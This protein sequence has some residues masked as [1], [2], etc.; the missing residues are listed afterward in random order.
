MADAN[1]YF[2]CL[3]AQLA[4]GSI[5]EPGN[6]GRIIHAYTL[7]QNNP[8]GISPV[9]YR[10][11]ILELVRKLVAPKKPSRLNCVFACPT[12]EDLRVFMSARNNPFDVAYEVETFDNPAIH[13]AGHDIPLLRFQQNDPYFSKMEDLAEEYWI[14]APPTNRLE[15]VIGGPVKVIRRL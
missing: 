13:I 12:E 9:A 11:L 1:R 6:W 4:P 15:V 8:P 2:H 7:V 3:P 5:I 10:E 14:G